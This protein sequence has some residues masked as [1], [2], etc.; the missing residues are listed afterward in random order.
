MTRATHAILP[1]IHNVALRTQF[2]VLVR[3]YLPFY[4]AQEQAMRRAGNLIITN[5]AA[6]RQYQLVQQGLNNPGFIEQ[7]SSGSKH[8]NMPIIGELGAGVITGLSA[9][10]IPMVSGL[11]V[12][13][14]GNLSSL[15][16]V[17]PEIN[18]PGLSPYVSIALNSLASID[19]TLSRHIKDLQGASGFNRSMI[20][21][22][23]PNAPMRNA[24]KALSANEQESSFYNAMMA[25]I[26]SAQFHGQ[27]PSPD[28][29]PAV[30]QAF[31]DRIKN[32]ARSILWMKALISTWSPLSPSVSQEDL[33]LRDE[34]YAHL[35]EKSAVTGKDMTFPEA[36]GVFLA[37]HGD[38]A[39][40]YTVGKTESSMPGAMI[41]FNNEAIGW[42]ESHQNLLN[43]VNA[44]GAAFL[45]PQNTSKSGDSQAIYDELLKMHLR[46]KKSPKEFME[47]IYVSAG[48]NYI[49][50]QKP[51]HDKAMKEL[52]DAG[53]SQAD[54]RSAWAGFVKDYGANN[55][56]WYADYAS[57]IRTQNAVHAVQQLQRIFISPD[58]PKD[59]Q[60]TLVRSLLGDWVTHQKALADY[61]QSYGQDWV[62]SEKD[63]W[64]KYLDTM[65]SKEPRLNSVINSVFRRLS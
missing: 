44:T 1:Q 14:T 7:D 2:G 34:F 38:S 26:A 32:N 55:P 39:I 3:N 22:L 36:L 46:S 65:V 45:V 42:I 27:Y 16:T 11:P 25:S 57:P 47:S 29:S 37:K 9:L 10:G 48:N 43:S 60:A 35:K 13:A 64:N 49:Y 8:L 17:L 28:A 23:I 54:E 4:F 53:L 18:L 5:P 12:T 24:F 61:S 21:Q 41:P 40:S 20:D 6:F 62:T 30:M 19:P 56:I 31:R 52:A 63:A 51:A 15:K 50:S 33:G 59:E 58:A